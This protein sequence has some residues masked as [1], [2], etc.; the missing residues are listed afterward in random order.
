MTVAKAALAFAASL[1]LA[2]PAF[3][4]ATEDL[5]KAAKEG[6]VSEVEAALEARADPDGRDE[7]GVNSLHWAVLHDDPESVRLLLEAGANFNARNKAGSAPLLWAARNDNLGAVKLLL[8]AGA[9]PG[10]RDRMGKTP[11]D[12]AREK[13]ALQGTE[14]Y[15]LLHDGQYE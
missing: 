1:A 4:G 2:L 12:L 3:A 11:F 9:D 10:A 13:G 7:Q 15:W 6:A 8:E 5:L 14:A